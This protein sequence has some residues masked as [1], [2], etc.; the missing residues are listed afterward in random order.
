LFSVV[1]PSVTSTTKL[2]EVV[3]AVVVEERH[4][5]GVDVVLAE[6]AAQRDVG[7]RELE[8]AVELALEGELEVRGRGVDVVGLEVGSFTVSVPPLFIDP[9]MLV[10]VGASLTGLTGKLTVTMFD[11]TARRRACT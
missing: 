11:S 1:V 4:L 5:V 2:A 10:S 7:P 8:A 3:I 9:P 6:L